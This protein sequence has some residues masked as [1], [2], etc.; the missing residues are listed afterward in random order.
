MPA[1]K[2]SDPDQT[3]TGHQNFQLDYLIVAD[4]PSDVPDAGSNCIIGATGQ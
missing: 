3:H 2:N 4:A 1:N